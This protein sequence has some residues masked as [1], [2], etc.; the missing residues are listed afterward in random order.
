[1]RPVRSFPFAVA[2][3]LTLG[4]GAIA[5]DPSTSPGPAGSGLV[6]TGVRPIEV[7]DTRIVSMSPDGGSFVGLRPAIGYRNGELCVFDLETLAERSCA[8]L[9]GLDA[10]I[11]VEDITWAP[12]GSQLAFGE[13]TFKYFIDGDLWLMDA[14]TGEL[15][16]LDDDGHEGDIPIIDAGP[17]TVSIPVSPAFS[18]DGRLVAFS[19]STIVDGERRGTD[20]ATVPVAGGEEPT[21]LTT[22]DP[23][24]PGAVY[25]GLAWAPDGQEVYYSVNLPDRDDLRNG[26]WVVGADGERARFILGTFQEE[27]AGPAVLQVGSDNEHIL[28]FDPRLMGAYGFSGPVYSLLERATGEA[29]PIAA[30]LPPDQPERGPLVGWTALSPDA[31]ALALVMRF[32]DPE[33]TVWGRA[34]DASEESLD[35]LLTPDGIGLAAPVAMG[36]PATWS[37]DGTLF[38]TGGG[39]L[40]QAT[41]LTIEGGGAP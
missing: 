34:V 33:T 11:R 2:G 7:E 30:R 32:T 38:L 20:I 22:V 12:D 6:V 39:A 4:A 26:I 25:Y 8:D 14:A 1:M 16:N 27:S 23:E 31:S 13:E 5:A 3:I 15:T 9:S 36:L 24:I 28:T 37:D 19:R 21:V 35:D 10:G 29:T 18:P 40:S 17:G 41:V